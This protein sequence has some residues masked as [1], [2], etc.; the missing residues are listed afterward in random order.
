MEKW[1]RELGAPRAKERNDHKGKGHYMTSFRGLLVVALILVTP[2]SSMALTTKKDQK[3]AL[4]ALIAELKTHYGMAKYKEK[5]FGVTLEQLEAKYESLIENA[6]TLE[7]SL[8]FDEP[9]KRDI[10]P[11]EELRQ[12]LIGMIAELRDGHANANRQTN[13]VATLG[14]VA[15][16]VGEKLIVTNVRKDLMVGDASMQVIQPGDEIIEL[17]GRPV[18]EHAKRNLLYSSGGT[19]E[20][21]F[22]LAMMGIVNNFH[23][24]QRAIPEGT[25]ATV[26]LRRD[27]KDFIAQLRWVY[28]SEFQNLMNRFPKEFNEPYVKANTEDIDITYGMRGTPRSYFKNGLLKIDASKSLVNIGAQL[29]SE[30]EAA[31]KEG[32]QP[33]PALKDLKPVTRLQL[34]MVRHKDRNVGV[35]RIPDYSPPGGMDDLKN[36]YLWLAQ[37]FKKLEALTDVLIIDQLSNTGGKVYYGARLMSLFANGDQPMQTVM[38]DVKLN[39]TLLQSWKPGVHKDPI[40]GAGQVYAEYR[41]E[42]QYYNELKARFE[43]GE[44]WSGLGPA[45]DLLLPQFDA[46]AGVV[47]SAKEAVFTKPILILNDH[48]SGSGGDFFPAQMQFNGRAKIMGETSCGLG[49]AVYRNTSSMPGSELQFRCTFSY[50]ELPNG[51][52]IENIGP[53]PDIYRPI[54]VDDLKDGFKSFAG[55]ALDEAVAMTNFGPKAKRDDSKAR[56]TETPSEISEAVEP[57]AELT[58]AAYLKQLKKVTELLETM[59]PG[60]AESKWK[61]VTIPLPAKLREDLIL[62]T[63]WQRLEVLYRLKEMLELKVWTKQLPVIQALIDLAEKLPG[64]IRFANPCELRLTMTP[65]NGD[66]IRE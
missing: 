50:A 11:H 41:L 3:V 60:Q 24:F 44:E 49:G 30:I 5:M 13:E 23:S 9:V 36:E 39:S 7:E 1:L 48:M 42:E 26:K 35:F 43:S 16:N 27:G 51:W 15:V 28:R 56:S 61:Q 57:L 33:N 31:K 40:D 29:N 19:F 54:V 53:V 59:E 34:Y 52:P 22:G 4:T 62:R 37:G 65:L 63:L 32:A 2:W 10:L 17:D 25:P 64:T 14:L 12:L 66:E 55:Q 20:D 47:F 38:T 58:G 8:G 18:L 45:F 6:Q 21:R 46:K